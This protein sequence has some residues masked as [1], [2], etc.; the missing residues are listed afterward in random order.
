MSLYTELSMPVDQFYAA[1][2]L[3]LCS[4]TI[5]KVAGSKMC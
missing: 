5:L 3:Y 1:F 2:D 4:Q